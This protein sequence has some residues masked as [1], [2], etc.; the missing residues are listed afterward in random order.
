MAVYL[1]IVYINLMSKNTKYKMKQRDS[2][3]H[4]HM[5]YKERGPFAAA[6][7]VIKK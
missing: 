3:V 2:W 6:D 4:I 5:K 1:Y 7:G